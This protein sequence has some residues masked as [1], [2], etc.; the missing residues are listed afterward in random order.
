MAALRYS[1]LDSMLTS[2]QND[3]KVSRE[4]V[5]NALGVDNDDDD[6]DDEEEAMDVRQPGDLGMVADGYSL[7]ARGIASLRSLSGGEDEEQEA[8]IAASCGALEE[9]ENSTSTSIL[10]EVDPMLGS[11]RKAKRAMSER[12]GAPDRVNAP[13][14]NSVS[15]NSRKDKAANL[16]ADTTSGDTGIKG[17]PPPAPVAAGYPPY[18]SIGYPSADLHPMHSDSWESQ[19]VDVVCACGR[20]RSTKAPR[21]ARDT[22]RKQN[23]A[24][25][26]PKSP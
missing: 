24:K 19:T 5:E 12:K 21:G 20:G 1:W 10:V 17:N 7:S 4:E 26:A 14:A 22:R 25:E 9:L 3:K 11:S 15:K 23:A 2:R 6:E 16:S 13:T 18:S 8:E